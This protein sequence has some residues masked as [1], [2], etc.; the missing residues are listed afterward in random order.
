MQLYNASGAGYIIFSGIK[1]RPDRR[2]HAESVMSEAWKPIRDRIL[3]TIL[4]KKYGLLPSQKLFIDLFL[5]LFEEMIPIALDCNNIFASENW[6]LKKQI[7]HKMAPLYAR[8]SKKNYVNCC[9]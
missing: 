3:Q 6:E 7:I 2:I 1:I 5:T 9:L 8:F 4:E